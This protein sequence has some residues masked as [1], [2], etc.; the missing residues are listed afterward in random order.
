M[1]YILLW[2]IIM[3]IAVYF[4]KIDLG[5]GK[6]L[7]KPV[8]V[9]RGEYNSN[10]NIFITDYGVVCESITGNDEEYN[11]YFG[12]PTS[13]KDLEERFGYADTE[14]LLSNY[15]YKDCYDEKEY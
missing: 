2:G 14:A 6:Y 8:N 13:L 9:I 15:L 11:D 4:E 7:F 10:T 3:D 1:I 12:F 5:E